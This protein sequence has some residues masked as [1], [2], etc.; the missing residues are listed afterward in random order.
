MSRK[1]E[2]VTI[3]F[4]AVASLGMSACQTVDGAGK[5]IQKAGESIQDS[6]R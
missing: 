5:D 6:S 4:L 3:V 1:S 2:I